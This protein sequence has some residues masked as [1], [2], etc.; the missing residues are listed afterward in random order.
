MS[1]HQPPYH[2]IYLG[3]GSNLGD[4]KKN[5]YDA[6]A[7]LEDNH[8][9]QL[10]L[11]PFYES[12]ALLPE[13]APSDWDIAFLNGVAQGQTSL[14]PEI[15]LD[16]IKEI[17]QLLGRKDRGRWGP[18]EIDIDILSY[19]DSIVHS[20]TLTIPHP[21]MTTRPFVIFPLADLNPRWQHPQ[22][23]QTAHDLKEKLAA[24][25]NHHCHKLST[26]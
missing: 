26:S 14:S 18:R 5:I 22:L 8:V 15:L 21:E 9:H 2:T 12:P 13:N 1:H 6:L 10:Q 11:S 25:N 17:E 20:D 24:S 3:L 7:L 4:R 16:H 19:G 23:N